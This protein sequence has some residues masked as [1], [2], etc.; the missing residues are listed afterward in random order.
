MRDDD[1]RYG[2]IQAAFAE[3][4]NPPMGH[5]FGGEVMAVS[6]G[7]S[8]ASEER[9]RRDFLRGQH[10]V[11]HDGPRFLGRRQPGSQPRWAGLPKV[12]IAQARLGEQVAQTY[13]RRGQAP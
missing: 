1:L 11:G 4:R 10:D 13:P 2:K 5:G 12:P 9:A 3:Q 7:P 8:N 6:V